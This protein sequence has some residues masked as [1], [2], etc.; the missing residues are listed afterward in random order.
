[1]A[2]PIRNLYFMF[3]YAWRKLPDAAEA[4]VGFDDSPD[5]VNLLARLLASGG[6]RLVRRGI[7]RGY[8]AFEFETRAPRGKMLMDQMI[9]VQSLTRGAAICSFDEL[10]ADV[11]HNQILRATAVKLTRTNGVEKELRDRLKRLVDHLVGVNPVR[12]NL[13]S[14]RRVQLS[15][16]TRQYGP[17]IRLCELVHRALIPDERGDGFYFADILK[18]ELI[19]SRVFEE[20]LRSFLK[21]EQNDFAVGGEVL[22][23]EGEA[24]NASDWGFMP[25]MLTD[26]VLRSGSQTIVVDAKFYREPF[27]RHWGSKKIRAGHLYQLMS[28]VRRVAADDPSNHVSGILIYPGQGEDVSLRYRLS[29]YPI[30]VELVDFDQPWQRIHERLLALVGGMHAGPEEELGS[31]AP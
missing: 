14:F 12:L 9:K 10:T 16:N 22:S 6:E 21:Q 13:G 29:G 24:E 26:I 4:E 31:R 5:V 28:Y 20:F 3:C 27:D 2:I 11:L 19:M 15:R 8:R 18:D 7:D 17:L 30:G 23:W 1:M 25:T